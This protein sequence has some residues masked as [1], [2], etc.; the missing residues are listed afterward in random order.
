MSTQVV[1]VILAG[2]VGNRFGHSEPKQFFKIHNKPVLYYSVKQFLD[3]LSS[4]KGRLIIVSPVDY[5]NQ[6]NIFIKKYFEHFEKKI[7]VIPGGAE[8]IDSYFKA[9][10]YIE[11]EL[12]QTEVVIVHDGVRPL[13]KKNDILFLYQKFIKSKVDVSFVGKSLNEGVFYRDKNNLRCVNREEFVS[14]QTPFFYKFSTLKF[15]RAQYFSRKK[16]LHKNFHI[17]ELIPQNTKKIKL[18]SFDIESPNTKLTTKHDIHFIKHALK[19]Y[20]F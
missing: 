20:E 7:I 5:M 1:A 14:S 3:F 2:G 16:K 9:T 18:T 19:S 11:K 15:L 10:D 13:I 8:R 17:L 6:T 4:K 12:P